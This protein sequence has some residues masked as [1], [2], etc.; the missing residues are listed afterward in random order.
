M[1]IGH[2]LHLEHNL[3]YKKNNFHRTKVYYSKVCG[4]FHHEIFNFKV[5]TQKISFL[6]H[7][8]ENRAEAAYNL[9]SNSISPRVKKLI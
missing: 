4:K 2:K 6:R 8:E 5:L 3:F 1:D 9:S 7:R